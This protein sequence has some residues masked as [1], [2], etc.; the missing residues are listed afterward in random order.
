[1]H[2]GYNYKLAGTIHTSTANCLFTLPTAKGGRTLRPAQVVCLQALGTH[3]SQLLEHEDDLRAHVQ[4]S[5]RALI[6]DLG[7]NLPDELGALL[8]AEAKIRVCPLARF[9]RLACEVGVILHLPEVLTEATIT[10]RT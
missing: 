9:L 8:A 3:I 4:E 7:S 1:M 5:W 2:Y 6:D 10:Y